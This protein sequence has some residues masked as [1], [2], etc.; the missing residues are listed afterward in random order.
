M[1]LESEVRGRGMRLFR[2]IPNS[3]WTKVDQKILRDTPDDI[4]CING[5][6]V[7]I[8][9]K[10][11][12]EEEPRPGQKYVMAKV[13]AAGALVFKVDDSNYKETYEHLLS[14]QECSECGRIRE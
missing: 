5:V 11:S 2:R 8:E 7:V 13:R 10:R 9:W 6:M 4:G 3:W 1:A 14:M 12:K